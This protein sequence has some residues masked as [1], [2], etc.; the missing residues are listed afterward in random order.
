MLG[1]YGRGYEQTH[2]G[3]EMGQANEVTIHGARGW[4]AGTCEGDER[5]S[6]EGKRGGNLR[7]LPPFVVDE[8]LV[9]ALLVVP[10]LQPDIQD[11]CIVEDVVVE[12][13]DLFVLAVHGR[14]HF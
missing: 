12:A 5:E 9:D 2:P 4:D 11:L 13:K 6:A 14:R 7:I 10:V 3:L 1:S 8:V